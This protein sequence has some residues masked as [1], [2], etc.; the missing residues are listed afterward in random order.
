M[1]LTIQRPNLR[2][3][4]YEVLKKYIIYGEIKPGQKINEEEIGRQLNVSRTPIRETLLRLEHEGIVRITPRR[5]AFVVSQSKKRIMDVL[6]LREFIEGLIVREAVD[7]LT[8][9]TINL[10]ELCLGRQEAIINRE[11]DENRLLDGSLIDAEFHT[12]LQDACRNDLARNVMDTVN[13]HLQFIRL[14]TVILP[15]R[16]EKTYQEHLKVMEAIVQRDADRAEAL[17]RRHVRSV[18]MDAWKNI[19]DD[20]SVEKGDKPS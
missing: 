10:L 5:G 20:Q 17:M 9:E 16:I 7:S 2:E 8:D 13:L 19:E 15:G 12:I 18:R 1:K 6:H 11:S 14:R 3:Q 4:I